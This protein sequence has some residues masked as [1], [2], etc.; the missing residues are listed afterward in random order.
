MALVL[1][2][3]LVTGVT[4]A[5][6]V[7]PAAPDAAATMI[8]APAARPATVPSR[9]ARVRPAVY[10]P[11]A[12]TV[13]PAPAVRAA[14]VPA[15]ANPAAAALP[16]AP[17]PSVQATAPAPPAADCARGSDRAWRI[18][19]PGLLGGLIGAGI[20]AAG[21]AIADGGSGAGKAPSS[22]AWRAWPPARA[23]VRGERRASA[24]PSSATP[25][26]VTG[27]RSPT[28]ADRAHPSSVAIRRGRAPRPVPRRAFVVW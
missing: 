12:G 27:S 15:S 3:A 18:A 8:P 26:R 13:A 25:R 10:H 16:G 23:T 7:R 6:L 21:G 1:A 11:A 19:K 24:A 17:A 28:R 5:Y 14:T 22:G 2:T 4:T 20:G 9:P